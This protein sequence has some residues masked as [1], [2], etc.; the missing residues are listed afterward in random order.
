MTTIRSFDRNARDNAGDA[1]I[2][3]YSL[4]FS[5]SDFADPETDLVKPMPTL[6]LR[7]DIALCDW[8]CLFD[9]VRE[10]LKASVAACPSA[11]SDAPCAAKRVRSA[12]V[13]CATV[14]D[15][16][17]ST[18]AHA[19]V[20]FRQMESDLLNAQSSLAQ[21]RAQPAGMQNRQGPTTR[22]TGSSQSDA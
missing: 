3:P 7:P 13:E 19:M 2:A 5:T 22:S 17:H 20:R 11:D 4:D 16:L 10:R 8:E 21:T 9:A 1:A 12:V 15:Q 18:L 14:L 6:T